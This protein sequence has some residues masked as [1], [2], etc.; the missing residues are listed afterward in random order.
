MFPA[1]GDVVNVTAEFPAQ[2]KGC[3]NPI[4][5]L[6]YRFVDQSENTR[7][8]VDVDKERPIQEIKSLPYWIEVMFNGTIYCKERNEFVSGIVFTGKGSK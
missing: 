1:E 5:A 7:V 3:T 2:E 6:S 8:Q 4:Y